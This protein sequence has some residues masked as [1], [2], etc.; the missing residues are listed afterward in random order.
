MDQPGGDPLG[1]HER[2]LLVEDEKALRIATARILAGHGYE[3][4][5]ASDGVEALEFLEEE[6]EAQA[7]VAESA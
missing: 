5:A 1:G 6:P 2:I 4:I 7:P 3:V